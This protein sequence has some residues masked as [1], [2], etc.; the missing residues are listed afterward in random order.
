MA[1]GVS[2]VGAARRTGHRFVAETGI[3]NSI[4]AW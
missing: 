2:L 1:S 4:V 3:L